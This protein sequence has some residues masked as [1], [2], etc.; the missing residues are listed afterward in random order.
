MHRYVRI[1]IVVLLMLT[2]MRTAHAAKLYLN[3]ENYG[4]LTIDLA[5]KTASFG[6][7]SPSPAEISDAT[8]SIVVQTY[9][10]DTDKA[11]QNHFIINRATEIM[12]EYLA[13][14][15]NGTYFA[16]PPRNMTCVKTS[17]P[18]NKF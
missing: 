11:C 13:D 15:R 9:C 12:V 4:L 7:G 10:P 5:T 14:L 16:R 6:A 3:C 1:F 18:T 17:A 2:C 8:I